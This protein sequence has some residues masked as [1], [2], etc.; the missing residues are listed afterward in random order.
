MMLQLET[1]WMVLTALA[2]ASWN[3]KH[4]QAKQSLNILSVQSE[5]IVC[6]HITNVLREQ[7][8]FIDFSFNGFSHFY[9]FD[10]I[11]L[12]PFSSSLNSLIY[13]EL[14]GIRKC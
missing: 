3:A 12:F 1:N 6:I 9:H 7:S 4:L 5:I 13:W 10:L 11:V 8:L 2:K 14:F